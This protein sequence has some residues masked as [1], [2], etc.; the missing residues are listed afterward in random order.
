MSGPPNYTRWLVGG[1]SGEGTKAEILVY[2]F[3]MQ[4]ET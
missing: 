3:N 1:H 2:K 4:P